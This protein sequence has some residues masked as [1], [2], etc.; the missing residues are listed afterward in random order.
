MPEVWRDIKDYEGLYQVSS[1]G[2]VRSLNYARTG[3]VKNIKFGVHRQGYLEAHLNKNAVTKIFKVHRLVA[4]AFLP[5]ELGKTQVNHIDENCSNNCLTN[6]EWATPSEN[7]N[8]GTRTER[9]ISK[10]RIPVLQ[11]TLEGRFV[12]RYA[13]IADAR[14][15][16]FDESHISKCC[17]GKLRAHGGYR[18]KYERSV[19]DG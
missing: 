1:L 13:S 17:K 8:H 5:N 14:K 12:E 10:I 7:V 19:I 11:F 6:L 15:K 3:K 4:I 2:D 9:A 18:W 16:G